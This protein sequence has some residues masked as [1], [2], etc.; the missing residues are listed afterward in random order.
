MVLFLDFHLLLWGGVPAY[1]TRRLGR[2][3]VLAAS[4]TLSGLIRK[5]TILCSYT[6]PNGP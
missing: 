3:T 1:H 2:E 4:T 6:C 5:G